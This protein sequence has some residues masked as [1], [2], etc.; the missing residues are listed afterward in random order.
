MPKVD[1]DSLR[2]ELY[3]LMQDAP[4]HGKGCIGYQKCV[5]GI[6]G[7]YGSSCAIEEVLQG[8]AYQLQTKEKIT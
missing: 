8:I 5:F 1:Y 7:C 4:C 2:E 3:D 6:D